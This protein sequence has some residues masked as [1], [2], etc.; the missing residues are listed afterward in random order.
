M[1]EAYYVPD[2]VQAAWETIVSETAPVP[3]VF[4]CGGLGGEGRGEHEWQ[5][6]GGNK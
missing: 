6:V 5:W 2:T 4:R 1:L 3:R